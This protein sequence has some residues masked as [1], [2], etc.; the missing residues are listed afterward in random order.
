MHGASDRSSRTRRP[1][2]AGKRARTHSA[3]L[4][5]FA[6]TMLLG[7]CKSSNLV[8]FSDVSDT[9]EGSIP[10]QEREL[11]LQAGDELLINV[12][13]TV[14]EATQI[15]NL[16]FNIAPSISQG[17]IKKNDMQ[18]QKQTYIVSPDGYITFPI[19]GKLQV[20]GLTTRQLAVM[21]TD[22]IARDV[23]DPYVRVQLVNFNVKVMGE[24][25]RPGMYKMDNERATVIDALAKAGDMTIH[26]KRNKVTVWREED[27]V[28]K[29]HIL[30]LNDSKIHNSPYYFLQQN[31]MVYVEPSSARSGQAD[32]NQNNS[33]KTSVVSTIVSACSVIASLVIALVI[34]RR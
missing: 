4:A 30:D 10:L 11:K 21:L 24:V 17:D 7:S 9:I 8:Y 25:S 15:Y 26:G 5:L 31:D 22:K 1:M 6:L 2:T 3:L 34:N 23:D 13:S 14:P 20:A 16:P 12:S 32:Y 19:L 29:Y 18:T 27:G 33:F 28:A